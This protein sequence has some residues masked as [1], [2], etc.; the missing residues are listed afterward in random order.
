MYFSKIFEFK[1]KKRKFKFKKSYTQKVL[2]NLS[3]RQAIVVSD[4]EIYTRYVY[5]RTRLDT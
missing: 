1:K 2:N 3:R 4:Y 5:T